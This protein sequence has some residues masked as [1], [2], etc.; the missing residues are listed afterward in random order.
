[1]K[2]LLRFWKVFEPPEAVIKVLESHRAS[3][4]WGASAENR[5]LAWVKWSSILAPVEKGGLGVGSLKAFN[6]SL[7]LKWRWHM[8]KDPSALWV[9]VLKLIHGEEAGFELS[10]C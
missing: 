7:L 1:M 3:F 4:F 2:R 9:N 5:K 8:L 6:L 10:G